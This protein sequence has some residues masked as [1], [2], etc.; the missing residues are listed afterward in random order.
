MENKPLVLAIEES[1]QALV[2]AVNAILQSGIPPYFVKMVFDKIYADVKNMA[3]ADLNNAKTVWS[4]KLAEASN[5][6]D[7]ET[8]N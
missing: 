5:K 6:G 2:G 3:D 1:E 7:K 8:E 4:Q